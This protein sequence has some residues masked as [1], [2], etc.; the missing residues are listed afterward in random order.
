MFAS[1]NADTELDSV[2][3]SPRTPARQPTAA[4]AAIAIL[5]FLLNMINLI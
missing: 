1:V 4:M 5:F 2:V 3:L